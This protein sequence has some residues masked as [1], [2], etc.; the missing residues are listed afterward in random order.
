MNPKFCLNIC[1]REAVISPVYKSILL[2]LI[3]FL[4]DTANIYSIQ[5][6]WLQTGLILNEELQCNFAPLISG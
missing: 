1:Q 3:L 5:E 2:K 6:I 4:K